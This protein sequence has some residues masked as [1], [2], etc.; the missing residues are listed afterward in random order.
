MSER[1]DPQAIEAR[2]QQR[3]L[4]EGTYEVDNDEPPPPFYVHSMYTYPS[5]PPHTGPPLTH[6]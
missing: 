5:G 1:Y 3:W 6:T 4:D 2:W